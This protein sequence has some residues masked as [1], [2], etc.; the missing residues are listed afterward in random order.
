MA[1]A[2]IALISCVAVEIFKLLVQVGVFADIRWL[3]GTPST[4]KK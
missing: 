1:D 2:M 3:P 4:F